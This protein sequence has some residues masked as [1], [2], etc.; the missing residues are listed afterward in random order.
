MSQYSTVT[1][2]AEV[3][4][5]ERFA[6]RG[7]KKAYVARL[8]GRVSGG[9]TFE[10]EFL[11]K[12]D[13]IIDE[14][15]LY[16]RQIGCKKGGADQYYNVIV[17]VDGNLRTS[18]DVGREMAMAIAKRMDGGESIQ[19]MVRLNGRPSKR[20]PARTV[21]DCELLSK[22]EAAKAVKAA[23][24]DSAVEACWAVLSQLPE[25]ESKAVLATLKQRISPPKSKAVSD[26]LATVPSEEIQQF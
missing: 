8:L 7:A 12:G 22:S 6:P 19:D 13:V 15:G 11:G 9:Q 17:E 16:E 10:R 26:A 25:K 3:E 4:Y 1:L 23:T 14:P 24:V 21:Y 20:D 18:L 2:S 5:N